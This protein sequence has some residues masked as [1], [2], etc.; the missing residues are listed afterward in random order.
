MKEHDWY[1]S[2]KIENIV[3]MSHELK[4]SI[5]KDDMEPCTIDR[6]E[7]ITKFF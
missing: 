7:P 3:F 6:P 2:I 1:M 5:I 4:K